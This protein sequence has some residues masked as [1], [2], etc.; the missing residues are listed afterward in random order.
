MM[1]VAAVKIPARA[2]RMYRLVLRLLAD[3]ALA[4]LF[5]SGEINLQGAH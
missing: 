2:A 4:M 1:M 3:G 5:S